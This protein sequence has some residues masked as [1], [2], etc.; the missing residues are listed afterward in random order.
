MGRLQWDFALCSS[1]KQTALVDRA[2]EVWLLYIR[3][4]FNCHAFIDRGTDIPYHVL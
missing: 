4:V 2:T 3:P 1:V